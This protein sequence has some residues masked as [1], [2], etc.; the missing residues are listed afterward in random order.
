MPSPSMNLAESVV[1]LLFM[2]LS[3]SAPGTSE[4][5]PGALSPAVGS[6]FTFLKV[7][8]PSAALCNGHFKVAFSDNRDIF[9]IVQKLRGL[10]KQPLKGV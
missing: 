10:P 4:D 9:I 2:A 5:D 1:A 7:F 8:Y 6:G 3:Q